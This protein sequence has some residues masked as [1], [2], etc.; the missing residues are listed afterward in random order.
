MDMMG[1]EEKR[2]MDNNGVGAL[3]GCFFTDLKTEDIGSAVVLV[4]DSKVGLSE[5]REPVFGRLEY[6]AGG[7]CTVQIRG[8]MRLPAEEGVEPKQCAICLNGRVC[9]WHRPIVPGTGVILS[10]NSE[11]KTCDVLL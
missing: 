11:D 2:K 10:V 4:G 1:M 5:N 9:N 7:A 8:I 3:Y 6:V